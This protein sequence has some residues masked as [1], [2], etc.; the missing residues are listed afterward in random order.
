MDTNVLN[1]VPNDTL[2]LALELLNVKESYVYDELLQAPPSWISMNLPDSMKGKVLQL[3][4][5]EAFETE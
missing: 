3:P 5:S 4:M 2:R 1:P